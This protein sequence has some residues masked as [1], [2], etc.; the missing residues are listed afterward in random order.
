M[1]TTELKVGIFTMAATA[2]MVFGYFWSVDGMLAPGEAAYHLNLTVPNADG[3]Y[4]GTQ[5]RIAGVEVGSIERIELDG[6]QAR[7]VL[8]IRSEAQIPTDSFGELG[9]SGLLG[10][11][12][13]RVTPGTE[14]TTL[15]DGGTLP[16]GQPPGDFD[17][18]TR[19]VE[20]ISQDVAAITKVLREEVENDESREHVRATLANVDAL[21][22]ELRLMAE[23][24]RENVNAIVESIRRLSQNLEGV[25]SETGR[26]IDE[27]MD[28]LKAA[29]DT[30]QATLDDMESIT[31][32]IDDGQGT[33]GALVNDRATVDALN[34]TIDNA[35]AVIESF[36]GLHAE[37]YYTG[38]Y[39]VG[40]QP[41]SPDFFYGNP[42]AFAGSNTV[43]MELHPQEDFWWVFEV[44]DYPQGYISATEHFYP[45]TGYHYTEWTRELNYRFTFQMAKRW[46]DFGFRIGI[47][48]GGGGLGATWYTAK[49]RVQIN[50]DV[51][52][53]TFGAYPA[54][55]Y[56]GVPNVRVAARWEPIDH[57]YFEAGT[58]Q[59]ALGLIYDYS[60]FYGGVGFHFTDDDIKLLFATLPLGL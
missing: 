28:K 22:A 44:N 37:V 51:F 16:Y 1:A 24:N 30:L 21:S 20:T 23:Q 9:S 33:I 50:L 19:Q 40:T 25:T 38:R 11:R 13:V 52:D 27:E 46:F 39:Y 32:K 59:V 29:T 12:Y 45:E 31:G 41:D 2:I 10:D 14:P 53:F 4:Q 36:S 47:K 8:T 35:N 6:N 55:E 58:E 57:L 5:V 56:S 48:E 26:D 60:T 3:V 15:P 7:I 54:L 49:D 18:I 43:G 34:E 42:L 17:E